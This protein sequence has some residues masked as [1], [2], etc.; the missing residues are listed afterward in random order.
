VDTVRDPQ[1]SCGFCD[2]TGI[3]ADPDRGPAAYDPCPHCDGS[4]SGPATSA[5]SSFA[6]EARPSLEP[7][8]LVVLKALP[9]LTQDER[10]RVYEELYRS[11]DCRI[12]RP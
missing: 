8:L 1:T 2:G 9:R 10:Q 7:L 3:W 12:Y 4:G 5:R 11:F 6:D